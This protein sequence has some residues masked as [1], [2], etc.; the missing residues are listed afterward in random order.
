MKKY[1]QHA[2]SVLEDKRRKVA[3]AQ[4]AVEWDKQ[5]MQQLFQ[6]GNIA[7]GCMCVSWV[8]CICSDGGKWA[9]WDQDDYCLQ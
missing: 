1:V 8:S 6:H 4:K 7:T 2:R 9:G 5:R 3:R